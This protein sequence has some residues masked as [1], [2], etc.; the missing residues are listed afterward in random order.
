MKKAVW[1]ALGAAFAA[2]ALLG[3][4]GCGGDGGGTTTGG[5][6]GGGPALTCSDYCQELMANCT[7]DHQQYAD[8]AGCMGSCA[9][10]PA[11]ALGDTA[12]DSLGCR[13][14][15]GGAASQMDPATHCPHAGPSGGDED[16]TD[17]SAG[18]CGDACESFCDI[19]IKA[20]AGQATA[21][22]DRSECLTE[23]KGFAA[24]AGDFSATDTAATTANDYNCRLYHL[25]VASS[26]AANAD[27]HCSHIRANSPVCTM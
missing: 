7:G 3:A 15:H 27:A 12:G 20:C 1:I 18:P 16:P 17:A 19:A 23:C 5:A 4:P 25:T 11:G 9:A 21:Y 13:L 6:G 22:A 14:Y 8:M 24:A 2:S 10:F 26:S